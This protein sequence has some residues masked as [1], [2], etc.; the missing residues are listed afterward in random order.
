MTA[1]TLVLMLFSLK[2]NIVSRV[3]AVIN[4]WNKETY[5]KY[6]KMRSNP[7]Q[8]TRVNPGFCVKSLR[9]LQDDIS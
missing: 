4:I 5:R 8:A 1:M 6:E 2:S 3:I 9:S 7:S